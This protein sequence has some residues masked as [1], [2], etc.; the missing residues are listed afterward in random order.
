M[1]AVMEHAKNGLKQ[2]RLVSGMP[3]ANTPSVQL[4]RNAGFVLTRKS[5]AS[6]AKDERGALIE[7]VGCS[8][9]CVL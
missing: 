3:E 6:F 4:L 9:E 2:R 7:F 8:F 5:T 1:T